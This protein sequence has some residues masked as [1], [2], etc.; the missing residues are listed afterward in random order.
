MEDETEDRFERFWRNIEPTLSKMSESAELRVLRHAVKLGYEA[1]RQ[2]LLK[3]L[4]DYV[5][6]TAEVEF[7]RPNPRL[8]PA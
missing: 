5:R 6:K 3:D 4:Y 8:E 7:N 1:G 2:I